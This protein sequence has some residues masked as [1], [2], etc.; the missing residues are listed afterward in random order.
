MPRICPFTREIFRDDELAP[1]NLTDRPDPNT[2]EANGITT[3]DIAGVISISET[4]VQLN[5][6]TSTRE[7]TV[8]RKSTKYK[9][10]TG[11][12]ICTIVG[13]PSDCPSTAGVGDPS[14]PGAGVGDLIL[15][16]L[17]LASMIRLFLKLV[18]LLH[19]FH[20][21]WNVCLSYV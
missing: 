9:S 18:S 19:Q 16:F 7:A 8:P 6:S 14:I 5:S 13:G 12:Q 3:T 15:P 10:C 2:A 17:E 20:L 1:S 4:G 11:Q 21:V